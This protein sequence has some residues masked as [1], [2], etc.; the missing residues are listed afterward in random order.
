MEF[1]RAGGLEQARADE[2]EELKRQQ[3]ALRNAQTAG[4][5]ALDYGQS[6]YYDHRVNGLAS[7][8]STGLL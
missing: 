8:I 7:A 4:T 2:I 1:I 5:N 6:N 3:Q